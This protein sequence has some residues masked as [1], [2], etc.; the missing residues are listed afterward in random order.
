[1]IPLDF[2][3][4]WVEPS[5]LPVLS[6]HFATELHLFLRYFNLGIFF[7]PSK[8]PSKNETLSIGEMIV[9]KVAGTLYAQTMHVSKC[10][11]TGKEA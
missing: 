7:S 5:P 8:Y 10:V 2:A 1:M 3:L 9:S 11:H 4:L 6:K